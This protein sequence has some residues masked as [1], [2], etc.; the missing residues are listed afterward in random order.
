MITLILMTMIFIACVKAEREQ[1]M[2]VPP[3]HQEGFDPWKSNA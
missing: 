1:G 3:V 2:T